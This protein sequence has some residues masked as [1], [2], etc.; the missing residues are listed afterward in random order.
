M[1]IFLCKGY[2]F[3]ALYHFYILCDVLLNDTIRVYVDEITET[4]IKILDHI[5]LNKNAS[6]SSGIIE[7]TLSLIK[8]C[9]TVLFYYFSCVAGTPEVPCVAI[10]TT[11]WTV[12]RLSETRLVPDTSLEQVWLYH[13]LNNR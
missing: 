13:K 11:M 3:F 1:L 10:V 2:L 8:Q 5:F 6:C 12:S 7:W 9:Y 4:L